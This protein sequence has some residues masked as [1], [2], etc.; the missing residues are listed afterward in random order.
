M[1]SKKNNIVT[2]NGGSSSIKFAVFE[3]EALLTPVVSGSIENIALP[4]AII[5][6]IDA[7]TSTYTINQ[8]EAADFTEAAGYIINWLELRVGFDSVKAIGHRLVHGMQHTEPL[9][10][11][12]ALLQELKQLIPYDPE[13]LPEEIQ[14]VELF[15]KQHPELLQVACFDTAFHNSMPV[16]AKLL[17]IPR[18]YFNKG[19]QRYG[20][21]GLSY[22]YLMQELNRIR[23]WENTRGKIVLAHLGNGASLAAVRNG[24]SID[25]SMGFTPTGGLVMGT[26]TG[27]LD[28][29][30]LLYL[31]RTEHLTEEQL[32]HLVNYQSGL[33]GISAISPDMRELIKYKN[34]D[35]HAAEAFDVFCYQTKKNIGA[36]AAALEGL[37]ILVFSGGIGEHSPEVRS[38][39][40]DG[41][42]FLGIELCEIKNMNNELIISAKTSK[43][44]VYVIKTNEE[45]MI[46]K[47]V[48][49]AMGSSDKKTDSI[50]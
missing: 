45:L 19:I 13:H 15:A 14:L 20:F 12:N 22:A 8:I 6:Y 2:V 46:A 21:H 50:C 40:C 44:S 5:R 48:T 42:E 29:G 3:H 18:S 47:L 37:D 34:T 43:V 41:L 35:T 10:I 16:V 33:L 9:R 38:Q 4:N 39:V 1:P 17:P 25:T 11:T 23:G 31:M 49:T 24:K 26:R 28:P 36:Y 27:E 32:N 30:V 7:S